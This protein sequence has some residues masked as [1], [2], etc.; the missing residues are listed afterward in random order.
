MNLSRALVHVLLSLL[1]VI[2]QQM[3]IAHALTHGAGG[4]PAVSVG[5][6]MGVVASMA[7]SEPYLDAAPGLGIDIVAAA[8][9]DDGAYSLSGKSPA[10]DQSCEQ[11]LAF[12]QIGTALHTGVSSFPM[13]RAT[14]PGFA[15]EPAQAVCQRTVCVFR[16]RAPPLLS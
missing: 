13:A 3:G 7:S 16:S 6:G 4:N 14:A 10:F 1:L 15:A 12:A 2:S 8:P 11:C 5:M 9:Q